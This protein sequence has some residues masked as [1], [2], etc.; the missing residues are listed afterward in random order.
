MVVN[1]MVI[2]PFLAQ[3]LPSTL[4][5]NSAR[6]AMQLYVPGNHGGF[7]IRQG[8]FSSPV[9]VI[10][11]GDSRE[12]EAGAYQC[13]TS[14]HMVWP[15]PPCSGFST[16]RLLNLARFDFDSFTNGRVATPTTFLPNRRFHSS[17]D[18]THVTCQRLKGY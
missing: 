9:D 2:F 1:I 3:N 16:A 10:R 17:K 7:Q 13:N 6:S 5:G 4:S 14:N 8:K 18:L 11:Q 12:V 15:P